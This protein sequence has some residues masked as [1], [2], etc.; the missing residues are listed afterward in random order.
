MSSNPFMSPRRDGVGSESLEWRV[1]DAQ[2][3]RVVDYL[4]TAYVEGRIDLSE[5]DQRIGDAL[6]ARTRRELNATLSGLATVPLSTAAVR[7]R[8]RNP[9]QPGP[10]DG[11]KAGLTGLSALAFGPV[12]PA[13]GMVVTEKGTWLRRQ[14]RNQAIF[15]VVMTVMFGAPFIMA[16]VHMPFMHGLAVSVGWLVWV[17]GTLT[18]ALLGFKGQGV[19][20]AIGR[21][22]DRRSLGRGRR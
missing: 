20:E 2:R 16:D 7:S 21:G 12:A 4:N 22:S 5:M 13:V 18:M 6:N 17:A 3:D 11:L 10:G 9:D 8:P 14:M 15:Q 1:T 19:A